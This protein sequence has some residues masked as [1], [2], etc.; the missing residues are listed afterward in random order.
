MY[1]YAKL[2]E[3]DEIETIKDDEE[4]SNL[5]FKIAKKC[6]HEDYLKQYKEESRKGSIYEA[7]G[8]FEFSEQEEDEDGEDEYED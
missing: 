1:E 5:L 8:P 3:L 4:Y 7:T 2:T 6:S